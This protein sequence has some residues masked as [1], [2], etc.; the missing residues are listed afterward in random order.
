MSS[1]DSREDSFNDGNPEL[2]RL[3][4]FITRD[5]KEM[6]RGVI[7][8]RLSSKRVAN[9]SSKNSEHMINIEHENYGLP[10]RDDFQDYSIRYK[11]NVSLRSMGCAVDLHGTTTTLSKNKEEGSIILFNLIATKYTNYIYQLIWEKKED[12]NSSDNISNCLHFSSFGEYKNVKDTLVKHNKTPLQIY[13]TSKE[14]GWSSWPVNLPDKKID[15]KAPTNLPPRFIYTLYLMRKQGVLY[16]YVYLNNFKKWNSSF[17]T[18]DLTE[19]I[20]KRWCKELK[21]I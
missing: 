18:S 14:N 6:G 16:D 9:G 4:Y 3:L 20:L 10:F 8:S 7:M 12:Y 15:G 11:K 17:K 13:V 5:A 2:R 19:D 21:V 1:H